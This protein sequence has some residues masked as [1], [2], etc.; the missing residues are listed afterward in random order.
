MSCVFSVD[1]NAAG[2]RYLGRYFGVD[3]LCLSMP[4]LKLLEEWANEVP[5]SLHSGIV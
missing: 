1:Y 2:S 3:H 4:S 5:P